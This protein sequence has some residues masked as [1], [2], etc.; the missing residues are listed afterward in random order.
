MK[1]KGL[2]GTL[3]TDDVYQTMDARQPALEQCI[4]QSRRRL[5][6]VNG[7]I[8]FGFKVAPDG[9]VAEIRTLESNIGHRVLE[10]CL[11]ATVAQTHF[12]EPDGDAVARFE[13][14]LRVEPA[15]SRVPE[16]ADP[17]FLDKALKKH[18]QEILDEC[19]VK[20]KERFA[21]TAYVTRRGRIVSSGAIARPA[22]ADEKVDCVLSGLAK[23]KLP[24]LKKEAKVSFELR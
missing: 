1:I 9:T 16:D 5:R 22:E 15:T 6:W 4:A 17:A 21:I 10:S 18:G 11:T 19:E 8:K 23:L 14:G 24:K 12:P 2:T 13:W 3:N 7:A 20:R